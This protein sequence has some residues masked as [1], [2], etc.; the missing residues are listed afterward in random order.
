MYKIKIEN[1]INILFFNQIQLLS[2]YETTNKPKEDKKS[3]IFT[4]AG[5]ITNDKGKIKKIK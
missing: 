1:K 3:E 2:L 5:P 4:G